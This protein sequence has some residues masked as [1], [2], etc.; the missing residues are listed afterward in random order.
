LLADS[1][2]RNPGGLLALVFFLGLILFVCFEGVQLA[3][4]KVH[5]RGIARAALE[6][7]VVL[8]IIV[9]LVVV[10]NKISDRLGFDEVEA[11]AFTRQLALLVLLA[12]WAPWSHYRGRTGA[13]SRQDSTRHSATE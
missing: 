10:G 2:T 13:R 1:I 8:P 11:R 5:L 3:R 6:V 4:G 9:L 12:V 7:L